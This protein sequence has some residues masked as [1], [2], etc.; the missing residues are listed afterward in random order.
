MSQCIS[1]FHRFR[2]WAGLLLL[3]CFPGLSAAPGRRQGAE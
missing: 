2:L 3:L 1:F